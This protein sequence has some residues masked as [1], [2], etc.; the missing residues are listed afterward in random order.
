MRQQLFIL[1]ISTLAFSS[2]KGK[3]PGQH[4]GESDS[5]V[6]FPFQPVH[7]NETEKGK[8]ALARIVL[9]VWRNYE[10]GNV[11]AQKKNF[12]DSVRIIFPDKIL[13]G[14]RDMVIQQLQSKRTGYSN[15]QCF[16]Y[17]WKAVHVADTNEDLVWVW[18][19]YDGTTTKGE[20]DYA[21]V[22]EIWR[23]DRNGKIR[24]L[25]QFRTHPH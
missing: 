11:V 18:G 4:Q 7:S 1:L 14:T 21:I 6:Y 23:F 17:S 15:M 20:R 16:V 8:D 22:H 13:D 2:C 12:A 10:T 25:E 5:V 24:E 9:D 3:K 19:L